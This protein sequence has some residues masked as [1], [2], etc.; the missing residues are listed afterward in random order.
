MNFYEKER[1]K[2]HTENVNKCF[3]ENESNLPICENVE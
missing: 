1:K 2:K 3:D